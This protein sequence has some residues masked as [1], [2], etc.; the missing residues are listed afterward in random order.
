[1]D[2]TNDANYSV[3]MKVTFKEMA[4]GLKMWYFV[5]NIVVIG[6]INFN[7]YAR[8]LVKLYLYILK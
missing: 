8:I 3:K 5:L 6:V 2:E 1:M 4:T 7:I